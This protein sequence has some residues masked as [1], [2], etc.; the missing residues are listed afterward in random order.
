MDKLLQTAVEYS[1]KNHPPM[2]LFT[3]IPSVDSDF[4]PDRQSTLYKAGN[5]VKG[6]PFVFGWTQDDGATNAGP[7]PAFQTE[8]DMNKSFAH[9]LTDED[10]EQLFSLYSAS[11]FEQDVR[12]YEARKAACPLFPDI[13]HNA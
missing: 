11:D 13:P 1:T 2:G 8:D 5:F 7:A 12:N 9:A 10:Y 4:L 3:F 6:V